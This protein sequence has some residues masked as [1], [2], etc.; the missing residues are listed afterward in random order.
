MAD[1]LSY[2]CITGYFCL[3]NNNVYSNY[4]PENQYELA[5][6]ISWTHGRHSFRAGFE[7]Q[8]IQVNQNYPGE[9][10]GGPVIASFADFLIGSRREK[11]PDGYLCCRHL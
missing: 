10:I 8:R 2:F 5:D 7:G 6:Q 3:G 9:S 1:Y 4:L 11:L